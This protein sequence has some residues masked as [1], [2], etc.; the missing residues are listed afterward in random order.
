MSTA[1]VVIGSGADLSA[2]KVASTLSVALGQTTTFTLTF[3]NSGPSAVTDATLQDIL[4]ASMRTPSFVSSA[5]LNGAVLTSQVTISSVFNGTA[6]LPVVSTLTV[7]LQAVAGTAG[8]VINTATVAPPAGTT[9]TNPAN[10]SGTAVINIGPQADLSLTKSATPTVILGGQT[11][12]FTLIVRNARPNGATN[13]CVQDALPS[14]LEQCCPGDGYDSSHY[15]SQ[16]HQNECRDH[17]G[18]LANNQLR[19][20]RQQQWASFCRRHHRQRPGQCWPELHVCGLQRQRRRNL[21]K[22]A[23]RDFHFPRRWRES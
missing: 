11:T 3:V 2:T 1:G 18:C 10:N 6:T 19:H 23:D 9:D 5:G 12:S 7:V 14:A 21:P 22:S 16:H 20:H 4:P 17:A 13:T 8:A 15:Q